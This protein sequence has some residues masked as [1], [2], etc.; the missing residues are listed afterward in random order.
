MTSHAIEPNYIHSLT[1]IE[2]WCT[3]SRLNALDLRNLHY[4][5]I[6]NAI[7]LHRRSIDFG[8]L[9]LLCLS[10]ASNLDNVRLFEEFKKFNRP[11]ERKVDKRIEE[12]K[13]EILHLKKDKEK[14]LRTASSSIGFIS[15][16]SHEIRT[17]IS[18][19]LLAVELLTE[20]K[21][22]VEAKEYLDVI[23]NSGRFLLNLV[24]DILDLSKLESQKFA[25]EPIRFDL[26]GLIQGTMAA[27]YTEKNVRLGYQLSKD[28]PRFLIGDEMRLRQIIMNLVSNGLKYTNNGHVMLF[29]TYK[30]GTDTSC[31]L[32]FKVVDTGRGIA[33][34]RIG[35]I[36]G[37][38]QQADNS[39]STDFGGTGLGLSICQE[40]CNLM[41]AEITVHSNVGIG[42]TFSFDIRFRRATA[43]FPCCPLPYSLKSERRV[44]LLHSASLLFESKSVLAYQIETMGCITDF[45]PLEN[46]HSVKLNSHDLVI[47]DLA[48]YDFDTSPTDVSRISTLARTARSPLIVIHLPSHTRFMTELLQNSPM[49]RTLRHPYKQSSLF[50]AISSF[51]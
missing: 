22:S 20:T 43:P 18:Q 14:A 28:V 7:S 12:L 6:F 38:F 13:R 2:H 51:S 31:D 37:C 17:P 35:K 48:D 32:Q 26:H 3:A 39:S 25:L 33:A 27:Y 50:S 5:S 24:N 1:G 4:I 11:S 36:F 23:T 19:M 9:Q 47:V 40:L 8:L 16:L 10:L 42:S 44:L 41:G 29:V 49:I 46:Y 45:Y 34:E 15:N 21:L 30:N